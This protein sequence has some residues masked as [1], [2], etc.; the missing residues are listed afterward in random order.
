MCAVQ[1]IALCLCFFPYVYKVW[2]TCDEK[3]QIF[4]NFLLN[5]QW[6]NS[7]F[8]LHS[9]RYCLSQNNRIRATLLCNFLLNLLSRWDPRHG[10]WRSGSGLMM[11]Q[12]IA[13]S[14]ARFYVR[15]WV[16]AKNNATLWTAGQSKRRSN[17]VY[18]RLL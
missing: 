3:L 7:R 4:C 8:I 16:S 2:Y 17:N 9:P 15:L 18:F 6:W 1:T 10:A 14:R 12:N 5:W 11:L 13:I